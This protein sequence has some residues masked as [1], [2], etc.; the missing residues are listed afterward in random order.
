[1]TGNVLVVPGAQ[2]KPSHVVQKMF[3]ELWHLFNICKSSLSFMVETL[4]SVNTNITTAS[5]FGQEIGLSSVS[6]RCNARAHL[7]GLTC[8]RYARVR[9]EFSP[10]NL[11]L[12]NR[13]RRPWHENDRRLGED[14]K[15]LKGVDYPSFQPHLCARSPPLSMLVVCFL[16]PR[17]SDGPEWTLQLRVGGLGGRSYPQIQRHPCHKFIMLSPSYSV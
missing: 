9:L 4:L 12:C 11:N 7:S 10:R 14:L 2:L 5:F 8:V 17:C 3:R 13:R 16:F 15:S 1:M 6:V